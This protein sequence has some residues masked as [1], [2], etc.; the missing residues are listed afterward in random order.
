MFVVVMISCLAV[1]AVCCCWSLFVV[2]CC[3]SLLVVV[4]CRFL[5]VCFYLLFG[6]VACRVFFSRCYVCLLVC[7]L[8]VICC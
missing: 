4:G 2:D 1:V 3:V 8:L 5:V 6:F 7:S